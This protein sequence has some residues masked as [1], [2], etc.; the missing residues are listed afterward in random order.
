MV[1]STWASENGGYTPKGSTVF[2]D[3]PLQKK[4]RRSRSTATI[5]C[6]LRRNERS[7]LFTITVYVYS[8]LG[9][10]QPRT[11]N[12]FGPSTTHINEEQ[13]TTQGDGEGRYA[14]PQCFTMAFRLRPATHPS[15][16]WRHIICLIYRWGEPWLRSRLGTAD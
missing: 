7:A 16:L 5:G 12:C 8:L 3:P 14:L 10:G 9:L 1:M 15:Y 13:T 4:G 6:K 11:V 2:E